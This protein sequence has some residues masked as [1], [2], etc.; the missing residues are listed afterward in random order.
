MSPALGAPVAL[1]IL[2]RGSE[3]LGE[4][5][6]VHHLGATMEAVVVKAPFIDPAGERLDGERLDGERI[7][8]LVVAPAISGSRMAFRPTISRYGGT[9]VFSVATSA[10]FRFG[11]SLCG[12]GK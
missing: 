11:G 10:L 1:G 6:R 3:R 4:R 12:G 9:M 8:G 2:A 7:D 5:V